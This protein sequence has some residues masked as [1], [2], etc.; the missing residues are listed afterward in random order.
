MAAGLNRSGRVERSRISEVVVITG[1][2]AG[3]GR[4]IAREFAAHG[5]RLALLARDAGRLEEAVKEAGELGGEAIA[6][7]TDVADQQQVEK[8]AEEA[9]RRFGPIDIWVN[10]A[11]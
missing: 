8:A 10:D 11:M 7:P 1:A 4:A 5:A 9:E 2:S 3:L 6:L